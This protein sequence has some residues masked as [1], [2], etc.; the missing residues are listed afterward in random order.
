MKAIERF[1]YVNDLREKFFLAY[2]KISLEQLEWK[3]EGYKNN[4]S[5]ILRH[6]AQAEDWFLKAVI[7]KE[8]MIPKRKTELQT[9]DQILNY[10]N[11]TREQ[12]LKFLETHP[13]DVLNE[14]R[15]IP[16]GYRGEPL[17]NPTVGWLIHRVFDHEVYHYGQVNILLRLQDINPPNM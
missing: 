15:T 13:I 16:E 3:P 14:T 8:E 11:E 17:D 1:Y 4:I 2:S 6:V 9:V 5:F 7:L 10:L 12:T